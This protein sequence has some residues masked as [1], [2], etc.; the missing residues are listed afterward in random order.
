MNETIFY[1]I[2]SIAG[3]NYLLDQLFIFLSNWFG[4]VLLAGLFIYLVFHTDKKKGV[5]DLIVVLV[6]VIST[7][8]IFTVLKELITSPRPFEVLPSAHVLY[9]Y[10]GG[11]SFPSGHS[12]F[13]MALAAAVYFYHRKL[14]VVYF[15]GALVI[16]IS[17][18]VVGIHWPF[19]VI[20]GWVLGGVV[21]TI[22]YRVANDYVNRK[23][24]K[25]S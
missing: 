3:Q 17:R 10:A 18:I 16:G 9:T 13:Y 23:K 15:I 25:I 5:Q 22:A 6:A 2:N 21:G 20:G 11:D 14:F 4:Y 1:A 8:V 7:T 12:A 24:E 19:D